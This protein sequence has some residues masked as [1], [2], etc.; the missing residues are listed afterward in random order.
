MSDFGRL[1]AANNL[2]DKEW[3]PKGLI[4]IGFRGLE[5]SGEAGEASNVLK[6]FERERL[7]IRGKRAT[8]EQLAEELADVIIAADLIAMDCGIDLRAAIATKFNKTSEENEL[9]TRLSWD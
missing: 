2:R 3:D 9:A 5:L 7:G 8:M 1:R 6:K 4:T